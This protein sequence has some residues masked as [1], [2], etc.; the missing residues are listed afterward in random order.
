MQ[1]MGIC[2]FLCFPLDQQRSTL[3][4]IAEFRE[5]LLIKLNVQIGRN[6]HQRS[7]GIDQG[8]FYARKAVVINLDVSDRNGPVIFLACVDIRS[9]A[10]VFLANVVIKV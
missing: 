10:E 5:Y 2:I 1:L 6:Q 3:E 7:T 4:W 8:V 9:L